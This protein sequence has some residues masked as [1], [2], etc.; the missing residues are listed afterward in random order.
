MARFVVMKSTRLSTGAV[1]LA[2]AARKLQ[3]GEPG[4]RE[5]RVPDLVLFT[6]EERLADPAAAIEHLPRGTMARN[7]PC[8]RAAVVV[9]ARN[10]DSREAL[11]RALAPL[12]R[13]RGVALIVAGDVR[14][15]LRIGAAGVHLS[16]AA[17]RGRGL[18]AL[19]LPRRGAKGARRLLVTMAA[20]SLAAVLRAQRLGADAVFLSPAFA[21]GSHPG[22]RPLGGVRFAALIRA[23]RRDGARTPVL[24]LGGVTAA[25]AK[26]LRNAR[27]DGL[28]AVGAL[29]APVAGTKRLKPTG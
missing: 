17:V 28:A 1:A 20:H 12:C 27:A 2:S 8:G 5:R 24:A 6:D 25:T 19:A 10:G 11:I 7:R 14:L 16:E 3:A 21:T 13:R 23:A 18:S 15:A 29:A 22:R 4:R 26:S 9:R